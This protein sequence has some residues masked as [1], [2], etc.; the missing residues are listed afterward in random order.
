[1]LLEQLIMIISYLR[2]TFACPFLCKSLQIYKAKTGV[3]NHD[4]FKNKTGLGPI[5]D[6]YRAGFW[7][8]PY[9]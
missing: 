2:V 5:N 1:M 8:I 6:V 3:A 7:H 9:I 4:V